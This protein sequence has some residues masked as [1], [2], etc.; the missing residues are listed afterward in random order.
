MADICYPSASPPV[1]QADRFGFRADRS[2]MVPIMGLNQQGDRRFLYL[3]S[4]CVADRDT[5]TKSDAWKRAVLSY[6]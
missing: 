6:Q 4:M 2:V 5:Y 1:L 3:S